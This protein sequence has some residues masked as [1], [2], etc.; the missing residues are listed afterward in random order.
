MSKLENNII[1]KNKFQM[2]NILKALWILFQQ[3]LHFSKFYFQTSI[4]NQTNIHIN[5]I[6]LPHVIMDTKSAFYQFS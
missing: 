6:M 2:I 1:M 3:Y 5:K 4:P